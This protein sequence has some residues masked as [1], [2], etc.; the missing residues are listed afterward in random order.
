M[1]SRLPSVRHLASMPV[2]DRSWMLQ[3]RADGL[4]AEREANLRRLAHVYAVADEFGL[5]V[6]QSEH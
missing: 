5:G 1:C 6:G 4:R 2:S 3:T